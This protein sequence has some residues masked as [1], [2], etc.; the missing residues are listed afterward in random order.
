MDKILSLEAAGEQLAT[1][2]EKPVLLLVLEASS[3]II[4]KHALEVC[5]AL[6]SK[7]FKDLLVV[8]QTSGGD[9]DAAFLITKTLRNHSKH[10]S[11]C[12]PF[13]AKSAGTM[14]C[15]GGNEILLT[16]VSELGPLDSQIME[17]QEGSARSYKSALNG[18]KALEQVQAHTL[19]TLSIAAKLIQ[20]NGLRIVD[21]YELAAKFTGA[22]SGTLYAQLDPK[23]IGEYARALQIGGKYGTMILTR[24]MGWSTEKAAKTMDRLVTQYPSHGFV[25]DYEEL[26]G[27][28][29]PAKL[30]EGKLSA[31]MNSMRNFL[32][33]SSENDVTIIKLFEPKTPT[34]TP[35]ETL[36]PH[37]SLKDKG[38]GTPKL[39]GRNRNPK[40][41]SG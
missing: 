6:H 10:V 13:Y 27:L 20:K 21:A 41:A 14:I 34:K 8:L 17:E 30:A 3:G 23:R 37:E 33:Q 22:T 31:I 40:V 28:E 1:E 18:F 24:Y 35:P 9:P 29:L 12:V 32:V 7:S 19:Q 2:A 36:K 5:S 11:V 39:G 38:N 15:L 26:V 25:V 16:E 4:R